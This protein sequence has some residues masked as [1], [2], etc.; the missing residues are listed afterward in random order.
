MDGCKVLCGCWEPKPGS[1]AGTEP[2]PGSMLLNTD[3]SFVNRKLW[4]LILKFASF[5]CSNHPLRC[6][7]SSTSMY[8]PVESLSHAPLPGRAGWVL[9]FYL[10]NVRD[11]RHI[12]SSC[13]PTEKLWGAC[14]CLSPQNS[15]LWWHV[16]FLISRMT[17]V[18]FH[19]WV[20]TMEADE[21]TDWLLYKYSFSL[22]CHKFL[23]Q[24]S[25]LFEK[26]PTCFPD[27]AWPVSRELQLVCPPQLVEVGILSF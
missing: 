24:Q 1:Y 23:G 12:V 18:L 14:C 8:S 11:M 25:V 7:H 20:N 5:C 2:K 17:Q 13:H 26:P 6:S 9:L 15:S 4:F 16:T 3:G 22:V 27:T 21:D 10:L 19:A